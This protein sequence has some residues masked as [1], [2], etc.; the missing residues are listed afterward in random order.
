M[1]F[2]TNNVI[3][4]WTIY[5]LQHFNNFFGNKWVYKFDICGY[6]VDL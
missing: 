5:K 4:F 2:D 3:S 6:E 1:L